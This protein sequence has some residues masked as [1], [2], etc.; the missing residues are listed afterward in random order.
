MST[1][2]E[3]KVDKVLETL[4]GNAPAKKGGSGGK[5]QSKKDGGGLWA[6][7]DSLFADDDDGDDDTDDG[8]DTDE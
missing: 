5:Q 8:D 7:L 6:W 2:L 1:T 4:A 3:A